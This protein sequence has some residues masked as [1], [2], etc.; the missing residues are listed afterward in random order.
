MQ[1]K[2]EK[3]ESLKKMNC[4]ESAKYFANLAY[5]SHIKGQLISE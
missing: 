2:L 5:I 4:E 1:E 3:L